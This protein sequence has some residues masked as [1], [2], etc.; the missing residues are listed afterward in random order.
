MANLIHPFAPVYD[1]NSKILILGTFPSVMSRQNNFYYGHPRNRFWQVLAAVLKCPVPKTIDEKKAFLLKSGI[2]LWDVLQ[3]CE[4]QASSDAS[5]KKPIPN[6]LSEIFQKADIKSVFSNGKSAYNLYMKHCYP[7]TNR[8][9]I[10]LPSTS[11][12][13]ASFS[14]DNLI[15]AWQIVKSDL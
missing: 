8:C 6:D 5:I 7:K 12:A 10:S 15:H 14:L 13:N 3:S 1:E 2:A 4:I 11:P 9:I